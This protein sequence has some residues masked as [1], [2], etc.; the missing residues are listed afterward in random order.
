MNYVAPLLALLAVGPLVACGQ[1]AEEKI[2][3][4][5]D[6]PNLTVSVSSCKKE[7]FDPKQPRIQSVTWLQ[8]STVEVKAWGEM[9]CGVN[10]VASAYK[11]SG[12]A[13]ELDYVGSYFPKRESTRCDCFHDFVYVISNLEKRDYQ[14]TFWGH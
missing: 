14:I 2:V 11:V 4:T 3:V 9:N 6:K 12:N 10:R 13:L 1:K 7:S 5:T 8:K